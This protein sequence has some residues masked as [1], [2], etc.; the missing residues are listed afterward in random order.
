[1]PTHLQAAHVEWVSRMPYQ[2]DDSWERALALAETMARTGDETHRIER[3]LLSIGITPRMA[4]DA[5]R[6]WSQL[7]HETTAAPMTSQDC[8]DTVRP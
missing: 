2:L 3:Q 8:A 7:G 1:L 4:H 6:H 5:A